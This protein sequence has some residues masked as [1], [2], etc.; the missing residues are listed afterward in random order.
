M[1]CGITCRVIHGTQVIGKKIRSL[2]KTNYRRGIDRWVFPT[3]QDYEGGQNQ[4]GQ[5]LPKFLLNQ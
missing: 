1:N 2:I 5:S 3:L 4:A